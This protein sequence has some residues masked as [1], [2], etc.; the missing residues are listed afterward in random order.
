M[1]EVDVAKRSVEHA[2]IAVDIPMRG[3]LSVVVKLELLSPNSKTCIFIL[4]SRSY[5]NMAQIFVNFQM[6]YKLITYRYVN[7]LARK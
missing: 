6:R 4:K 7:N 5:E 3:R 2:M 1:M